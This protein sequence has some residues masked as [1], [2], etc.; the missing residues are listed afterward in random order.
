MAMSIQ[1]LRT[2]VLSLPPG[3][4]ASIARDLIRSLGDPSAL[5]FTPE[6]EAEIRRRVELVESGRAVG[7]P[8][9]EMFAYLEARLPWWRG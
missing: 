1:E 2:A 8:A 4:R 5:R 3:D 9:S 7:R 6:Y